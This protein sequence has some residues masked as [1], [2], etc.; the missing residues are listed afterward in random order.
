M[1]LLRICKRSKL[2]MYVVNE[3]EIISNFGVKSYQ[4]SK[5]LLN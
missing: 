4:L 1:Q 2:D 3:V 5:K